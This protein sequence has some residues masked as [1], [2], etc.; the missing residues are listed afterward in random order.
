MAAP[1]RP[2]PTGLFNRV[3]E[4]LRTPAWRLPEKKGAQKRPFPASKKPS[5]EVSG[6]QTAVLK[7][8]G[9]AATGITATGFV[10][11]VGAA[12]FWFRFNELHLPATQAVSVMP[13]SELLVQGAQQSIAFVAIALAAVLLV[14][15]TDPQGEVLGSTILV[16]GGL[17]LGAICYVISTS[18]GIDADIGLVAL[19]VVLLLGCAAI[20]HRSGTSFWPLALAIFVVTLTYSATVGILVVKQ[21]KYAQAVA[22]LR[23]ADDA[24][25]T[26]LYITAAGETI[27]FG[28]ASRTAGDEEK[29]TVKRALFGDR[30][31]ARSVREGSALCCSLRRRLAGEAD[32]KMVDVVRRSRT[33]RK[34]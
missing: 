31:Q 10:V 20:G 26:G 8:A 16:L 3:W 11:V 23:G 24:G 12:V 21:Q 28:R 17:A 15:F 9:A 19:A 7:V 14:F 18:L 13:K 29:E 6:V 22:I 2:E 32:R 1:G 30:G 25:V 34:H 27:Y 33:A 4:W 5:A